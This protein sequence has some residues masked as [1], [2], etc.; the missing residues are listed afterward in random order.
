ML[1]QLNVDQ[2]M[3]ERTTIKSQFINQLRKWP[4]NFVLQV[5]LDCYE[6]FNY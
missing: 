5:G 1:Q 6:Q 4:R 3:M 2:D